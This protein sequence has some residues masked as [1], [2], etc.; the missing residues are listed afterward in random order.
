MTLFE[1]QKRFK[2]V[3][4]GHVHRGQPLTVTIVVRHLAVWA[5]DV[6]VPLEI[7]LWRPTFTSK[8]L[9]MEPHRQPEL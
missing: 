6:R 7:N 5:T 1:R 8:Y 3:N 4:K 9:P 2:L